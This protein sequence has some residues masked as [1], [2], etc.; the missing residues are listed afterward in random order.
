MHSTLLFVLLT[1]LYIYVYIKKKRFS[2]SFFQK[3]KNK[4][5]LRKSRKLE[6]DHQFILSALI[7][8][9]IKRQQALAK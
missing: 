5:N 1:F 2:L 9:I 4:S 8:S 3:K 6:I 7:L